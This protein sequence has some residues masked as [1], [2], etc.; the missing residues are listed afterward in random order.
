M[1]KN[2]ILP[3]FGEQLYD[4]ICMFFFKEV[5]SDIGQVHLHVGISNMLCIIVLDLD[6]FE[7]NI[8]V[9]HIEKNLVFIIIT[10]L[11]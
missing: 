4:H 1:Q 7:K 6:N 8:V 3:R 2:N 10:E 9:P 5:Y 11:I